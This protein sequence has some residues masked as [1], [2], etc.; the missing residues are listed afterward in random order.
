LH[1]LEFLAA[2]LGFRVE[3]GGKPRA[4]HT[5]RAE[6]CGRPSGPALPDRDCLEPRASVWGACFRL[7][8]GQGPK[9]TSNIERST[10]NVE[11]GA[12]EVKCWKLDVR[13]SSGFMERVVPSIFNRGPREIRGRFSFS[14]LLSAYSAYSAV[15]LS[16]S[17]FMPFHWLRSLIR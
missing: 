7:L 3:S 12:I 15:R 5:L 2:N 9:R 6:S 16:Y 10:S 14:D 4:L 1:L 13:C 8:P 17:R 11:Q